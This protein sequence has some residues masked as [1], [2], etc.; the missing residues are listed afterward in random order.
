[1]ASI[2]H[3]CLIFIFYT[4]TVL[5]VAMAKQR[6]HLDFSFCFLSNIPR[7]IFETKPTF[8]CFIHFSSIV[9]GF[10]NEKRVLNSPSQILNIFHILLCENKRAFVH[11]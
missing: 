5:P 1:M 3:A 7:Q 4:V 6:V 9:H 11:F 10:Q 8:R 2:Y